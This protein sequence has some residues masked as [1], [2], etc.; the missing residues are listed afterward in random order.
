MVDRWT[1]LE[2]LG[3]GLEKG[4]EKMSRVCLRLGG[5]TTSHLQYI[6]YIIYMFPYNIYYI[7]NIYVSLHTVAPLP[8]QQLVASLWL[9]STPSFRYLI[10]PSGHAMQVTKNLSP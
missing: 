9:S 1:D 3:L 4:P 6:L 10:C 7:Y 5:S 2:D 8:I